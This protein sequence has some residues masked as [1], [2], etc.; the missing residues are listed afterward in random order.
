MSQCTLRPQ[1]A[2]V[3]LSVSRLTQYVLHARHIG[4][5]QTSDNHLSALLDRYALAQDTLEGVLEMAGRLHLNC[6]TQRCQ[7]VL[8]HSDFQLTTGQ[9]T[10]DTH[11]VVKWAH[12][13]QKHH[14]LVSLL[15]RLQPVLQSNR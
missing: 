7:D 13:A 8:A 6:L 4:S 5:Q 12:V 11:S 3:R 15:S 2:Y 14:L 1:A 10:A 9:S